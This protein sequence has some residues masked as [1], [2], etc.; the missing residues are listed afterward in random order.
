[1]DAISLLKRDH[2]EVKELFEQAESLSER[3]SASRGKLREKIARALDLHTKIEEEIFYPAFRSRAEDSEEREKILEA[4]EEH[5]VAKMLLGEL[6]S[7]DPADETFQPKLMVLA[8]AVRHHIKEEEGKIFK[9]ARRLFDRDELT[10][11][12]E[13]LETAKTEEGGVTARG[14]S[15]KGEI[16]APAGRTSRR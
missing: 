2:A 5:A 11:L 1:M 7:L 13:K 8:E 4:F 15:R 14:R 9:M 10:E 16:E 6:E 3:A 12:G